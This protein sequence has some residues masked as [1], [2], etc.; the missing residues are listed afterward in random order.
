[1]PQKTNLERF[2]LLLPPAAVEIIT[3]EAA[4]RGVSPR[5]MGRMLVIEK[6]KDM[7]GLAPDDILPDIIS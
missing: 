1:M 4:I 7:V 6:V 5:V 2:D 3:K